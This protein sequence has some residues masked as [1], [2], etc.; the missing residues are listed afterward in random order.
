MLSTRTRY[1]LSICTWFLTFSSSSNSKFLENVKNQFQIDRRVN[2]GPEESTNEYWSFHFVCT[3]S[4]LEIIETGDRL[5]SSW[6]SISRDRF[7]NT[8]SLGHT[9]LLLSP[10]SMGKFRIAIIIETLHSANSTKYFHAHTSWFK[11]QSF[12]LWGH[13]YLNSHLNL[14]IQEI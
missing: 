9:Y 2:K 10:V 7:D 11:R 6:F 3:F 12:A 14:C 1:L 8:V 4:C 13:Q 5:G